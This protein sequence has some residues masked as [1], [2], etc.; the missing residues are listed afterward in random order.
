M[1]LTNT[2]AAVERDIENGD[3]GKARDRLHGL[4]SAYPSDLSLRRRLGQVYWDL[5]YPAMAGRYWYLEEAKTPTMAAACAAF[6]RSCGG[7]PLKILL[8]IKYRGDLEAIQDTYA[9][10]T[11][12]ELRA[13]AK[14]RY[15]WFPFPV[16]TKRETR[17]KPDQKPSAGNAAL[18]A[19]CLI[20]GLLALGLMVVGAITVIQRIFP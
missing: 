20:V 10:R 18:L 4:V 3:L 8:A 6:E 17:I 15:P 14:A 9:G 13:Q 2:L 5:R 11:L 12:L 7:D 19:G 1:P 16:Q